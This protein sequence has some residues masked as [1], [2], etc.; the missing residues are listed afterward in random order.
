MRQTL[1]GTY[2]TGLTESTALQLHS[3]TCLN[4]K[5]RERKGLETKNTSLRQKEWKKDGKLWHGA[6]QIQDTSRAT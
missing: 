6:P 1:I 3:Q 4:E 5:V 2:H